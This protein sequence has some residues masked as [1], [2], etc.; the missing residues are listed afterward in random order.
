[1]LLNWQAAMVLSAVIDI[2]GTTT[3]LMG[4]MNVYRS[5]GVFASI[6]F[7]EALSKL[8]AKGFFVEEMR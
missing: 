3:L 5:L 1:V 7:S 6:R 4:M 8:M 2:D